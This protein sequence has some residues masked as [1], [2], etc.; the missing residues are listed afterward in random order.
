[1]LKNYLKIV[2]V[3][4]LM[5][6]M[7]ACNQNKS[8]EPNQVAE[9]T[10]PRT[11]KMDKSSPDDRAT[12]ASLIAHRSKEGKAYAI[13][14]SGFWNYQF[15]FDGRE[16]S[17]PGDYD[18]H[19]IQY[20]DDFTYDYGIYGDQNGSG[21]YHY[22]LDDNMMI[23]LDDDETVQP[24]EWQVKHGGEVMVLVGSHGFGNNGM[25]MKMLKT[26]ERPVKSDG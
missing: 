13:L 14:T 12:A 10:G 22:R 7:I 9:D 3:L 18:G 2:S 16:M 15:V 6:G 24:K 11:V 8:A 17:K 26:P 5:V 25:Q 21:K 1:M 20:K 19:W 4:I 23:M